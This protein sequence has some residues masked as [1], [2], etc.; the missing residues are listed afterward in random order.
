[1]GH[2]RYKAKCNPNELGGV[3]GVSFGV[4]N[5]IP[6][7]ATGQEPWRFVLLVT[8]VLCIFQSLKH[9]PFAKSG[10][11]RTLRAASHVGSPDPSPMLQPTHYLSTLESLLTIIR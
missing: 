7:W 3:F 9:T 11:K 1:M 8:T 6:L 4:G 2:G 5:T 10:K